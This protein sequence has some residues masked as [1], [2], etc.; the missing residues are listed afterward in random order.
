[1]PKTKRQIL[2]PGEEFIIVS[3]EYYRWYTQNVDSVDIDPSEIPS[4]VEAIIDPWTN[5]LRQDLKDTQF[6]GLTQK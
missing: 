4:T 2:I 5:S 1:M 3:R 6:V